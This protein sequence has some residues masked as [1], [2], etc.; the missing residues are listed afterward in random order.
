MELTPRLKLVAS[1]VPE[2]T[3]VA[4]IGTDH[5]YLLAHLLTEGKIPFGIAADLREGPLSR[6]KETAKLYGCEDRVSFRLCDGLTG[7]QAGEMD[8]IVIAGMGGETI[9]HILAAAPW[10]KQPNI[11]LILQPMSTQPELREWL[12][13]NGCEIV[14]EHLAQ[15]GET[16]YVVM[17]VRGGQS[18]PYTEGELWAGKQS[19]APLRGAYLQH[20]LNRL[21]RAVL[22]LGQ[23]QQPE[24]QE[25]KR[26]LE[27]LIS[28][29]SD[30]KKE[31]EQWQP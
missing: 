18:Q 26:K 10:A 2:G 24:A 4:D 17:E 20:Q 19:H 30:M 1:L 12:L 9:S 14:E 16:L 6:A 25:R 23:S 3:R 11:S 22:G 8:I 13:S 7:L 29:L 31:W 21:K 15:E 28:E 5:A 27:G